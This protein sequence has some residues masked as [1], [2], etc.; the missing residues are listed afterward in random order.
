MH[1]YVFGV[2]L[3]NCP[4]ASLLGGAH[5]C[6]PCRQGFSGPDLIAKTYTTAVD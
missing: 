1:G 6:K 3:L 5:E 4:M 2:L